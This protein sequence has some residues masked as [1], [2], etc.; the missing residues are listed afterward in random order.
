MQAGRYEGSRSAAEHR[1]F[2]TRRGEDDS[3]VWKINWAGN[4]NVLEQPSGLL[5]TTMWDDE[6]RRSNFL[7]PDGEITT[8]TYRFDGLRDSKEDSE[9]TTK[10]FWDFD[11]Y[12]AET[13]EPA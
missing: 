3:A 6:N 9:G 11:N 2:A 1:M 10:Y 12:L 8:C 7:S 13:D 4:L 5:T